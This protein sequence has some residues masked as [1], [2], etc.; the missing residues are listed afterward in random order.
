[1][2]TLFFYGFM[3]YSILPNV[4]F[5]FFSRKVMRNLSG[6]NFE[7]KEISLTFDDGPDERYTPQLLDL[8]KQHNIKVT[9]F[10]LGEKAEKYPQLIKRMAKEGHTV[11]LHANKHVGAPFRSYKAMKQDFHHSIM[12]L[13]LLGITVEY[14]RPPWGLVNIISA[15]FIKKYHFKSVL[16]TIH[17]SDWSARVDQA[18][19]EKVL[20]EDVRAGDIILLHDGR[21]AEGAP[22]RT[23][24]ALKNA[25]PIMKE[26]G[27]I[28]VS[29]RRPNGYEVEGEVLS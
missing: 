14:Y 15:K 29:P 5:R 27:F 8:L 3:L 7:N 9:F 12:V 22:Q 19:I 18:H 24:D 23:I 2:D 10:V 6:L 13:K 25:L 20:T 1:M 4:Y 21:G 28:F 17:A 26:K 16:W 11:G